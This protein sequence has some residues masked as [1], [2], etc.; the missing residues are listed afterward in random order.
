M[1]HPMQGDALTSN[2]W[3]LSIK[4]ADISSLFFFFIGHICVED[5]VFC[6]GQLCACPCPYYPD[7]ASEGGTDRQPRTI[8]QHKKRWK[9]K[10][11]ETM[12]CPDNAFFSLI[13]RT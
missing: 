1:Q 5:K 9:S 12:V 6:R 3:E 7:F 13:P 2:T 4:L 10:S 11:L 8:P